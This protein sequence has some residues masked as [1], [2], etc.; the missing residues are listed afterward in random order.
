MHKT[1]GEDDSILQDQE[2]IN[3]VEKQKTNKQMNTHILTS[4]NNS[5]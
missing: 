2:L 1:K 5:S 4:E 3:R